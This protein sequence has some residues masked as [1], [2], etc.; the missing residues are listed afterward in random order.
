MQYYKVASYSFFLQLQ[1]RMEILTTLSLSIIF[2]LV[3]IKSADV[4]VKQSVALAHKFKISE[5]ITG[6]ALVSVGTSIP[7]LSTGI[8]STLSGHTNL[9]VAN[10]IG[11]N[12]T[13]I[14]LLLG[15]IAVFRSFRISKADVRYNIPLLVFSSITVLLSLYFTKFQLTPLLGILLISG[16]FVALYFSSR[17][18]HKKSIS[19]GQK[20][21]IF[22]L[23]ASATLIVIFSK[24]CIDG[25]IDVATQLNI[26]ETFFGYIL[27]ALGTSL[28]ELVTTFQA[29]KNGNGELGLGNLLGS[30]MFNLL[31]ILGILPLIKAA[32]LSAFRVE[33]IYLVTT[34][35]L[36]IVFAHMGKK[37]FFSKK[38]GLFMLLIYFFYIFI[39]LY[40]NQLI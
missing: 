1:L 36:L 19:N 29:I 35:F 18:N 5:F 20:F 10:I 40:Q 16:F 24:F 11:S 32:D 33:M 13:N 8:Y 38:E 37:Y 3:V 22:Y 27:I 23:V 2:L 28:P 14:S 4:F 6:F 25:I 7:E 17:E 9:A 39:V 30:N 26:S 12:I 15:L 31:L 21:N 34:T